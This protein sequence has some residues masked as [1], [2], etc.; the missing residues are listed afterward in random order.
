MDWQGQKVAEQL[1]QLMQLVF[2]VVALATG[3]VMG[4]FQLMVLIYAAGVV[5]T[6][7]I[8]VPNWPF[9]NRHPLKWLEPSEADRHPKPQIAL[10]KKAAKQK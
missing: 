6:A 1:L 4:S 10:K 2:A 3:Y 7:V 8:I 9:F 5:L